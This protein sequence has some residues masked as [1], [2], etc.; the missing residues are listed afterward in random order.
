MIDIESGKMPPP[1][2]WMTR[3][4]TSGASVVA[5]A[6]TNVPIATAVSAITRTRFLPNMSPSRPRI[7]VA[8]DAL[9]R[10]AVRTQVTAVVEVPRSVWISRRAGATRDCDTARAS[11]PS[12]RKMN[13]TL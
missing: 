8:T 12:A 10:N 6:L 13:V 9:S 7:G 11:P 4:T 3:P 1:S 2:P 5:T